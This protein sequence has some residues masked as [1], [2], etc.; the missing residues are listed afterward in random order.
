MYYMKELCFKLV[1]YQKQ[2]FE[3]YLMD[4]GFIDVRMIEIFEDV[5]K[6]DH[7]VT[8]LRKTNLLVYVEYME[9]ERPAT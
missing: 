1:T 3:F 9:A 8:K 6:C 2:Q 7:Q 4:I 5:I